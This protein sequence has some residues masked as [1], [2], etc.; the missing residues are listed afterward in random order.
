M[1]TFGKKKKK[2]KMTDQPFN[3]QIPKYQN[4]QIQAKILEYQ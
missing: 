1:L 4:P 2:N 3:K